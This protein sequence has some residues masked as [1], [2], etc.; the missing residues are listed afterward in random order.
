MKPLIFHC[1]AN[2][3]LVEARGTADEAKHG[4]AARQ[5]CAEQIQHQAR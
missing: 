2:V 3:E 4:T 5:K 1:E